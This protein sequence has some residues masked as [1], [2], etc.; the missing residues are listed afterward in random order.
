MNEQLREEIAAMAHTRWA[1]VTEKLFK[2]LEEGGAIQEVIKEL[3][4][5]PYEELSESPKLAYRGWAGRTLAAATSLVNPDAGK[6]ME[7]LGEPS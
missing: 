7:S 5:T 6:G 3:V 1:A 4:Q 2:M